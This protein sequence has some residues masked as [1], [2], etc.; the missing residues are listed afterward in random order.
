[1]VI[2][3]KDILGKRVINWIIIVLYLALIFL[4]SNQDGRQSN[5]ISNEITESV[6]EYVGLL[7]AAQKAGKLHKIDYNMILR[8]FTHFTE[9]FILYMLILRALLLSKVRINRGLALALIACLLYA[10]SD[11]FHQSFVQA[12]TPRVFDVFIDTLGAAL[13]LALCIIYFRRKVRRD[14]SQP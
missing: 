4:L 10:S 9:Y 2:L 11:E 7:P 12:R 5:R 13:A 6:K 8:K 14:T 1:V 3:V